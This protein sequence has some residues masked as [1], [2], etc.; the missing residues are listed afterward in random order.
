MAQF[1][2]ISFRTATI[3][4]LL[5]L[6]VGPAAA[7]TGG[8]EVR[9]YDASG[10]SP[11]AG[12]SVT[13]SSALGMVATTAVSTGADGVAFFPVLRPGGGYVVEVA[14][15]G[16]ARVRVTDVRVRIQEVSRIPIRLVS[17]I[18]ESVKVVER[19]AEVDL[20]KTSRS[21]TFDDA[22]LQ[23]LPSQ[24]RF[25][26]SRL[27]LAPGVVDPDGDGNPNVHGARAVDFQTQ[28]GGVSNQDPLTGG[29]MSYL[30]P[31]SIE[32]I[33][34][35]GAGAGVEFGRA[36]GGFAQ[37]IQKQGSNEFEGLANLLWRS[38]L[39][40]GGA[41]VGK[42]GARAPSY[43][44][45]QPAI[46]LS[47]PII[48]DRLWYRLSHEYISRKEPVTVLDGT[49]LATREQRI[50]S[51]QI[52]WQV[53]PRNKLALA[54]SNDPLTRTYVGASTLTTSDSTQ[55]YETG[56]PT[57][58]LNWT[59]PASPDVLVD[60]V[61]S[62]QNGHQRLLPMT[63]GTRNNC[64]VGLF[65][66]EALKESH[67]TDT[68]TGI[69]SGPYAS[70]QMDERQRLT[71][72]SQASIFG[73]RFLG[74]THQ[75]KA[76]INIENERYF[77][78]L[79][80][81]PEMTMSV[82]ES[83]F[84]DTSGHNHRAEYASI[85]IQVASP[86][87]ARVNATDVA[88]G[89]FVEDQVKPLPNLSLTLGF[90]VDRE[91]LR[92]TGYEP[93]DP[94]AESAEF[95]RRLEGGTS[96]GGFTAAAASFTS[97]GTLKDLVA[98]MSDATGYSEDKLS[99]YISVGQS[100]SQLWAKHRRPDDLE[101]LNTNPSPRLS[102]AWDPGGKGKSKL[103]LT[104]GR[105]YGTLLLAVPLV[106]EEPVT[107][108]MGLRAIRVPP[109]PLWRRVSVSSG[110]DPTVS[111]RV[112]DR[113]LRTPYQDEL[114]ISLEHE[115]ARETLARV[116]FISRR[117]QDQLQDVDINHHK[118]DYGRCVQQ[119]SP[120]RPWIVGPPDGIL[121]DCDGTLVVNQAQF[122]SLPLPAFHQPDGYLDSYTYNPG[123]G[124]IYRVGNEDT[125]RYK[126]IV[127]EVVRRQYRNWQMQAS[128]TW[129]RAL[130]NGEDFSSNVGD[131]PANRETEYG[132]LAYDQRNVVKVNATT[133]T[134][135]GFRFGGT[136]SW[137]SGLPY[138]IVQVASV[139]DSRP[140]DYPS[141]FVSGI[142]SRTRYSTHRRNDQRNRPSLTLNA[143][144][145]KEYNL[146]G[147]Q[148]LQISLEV[149][150]LLNDRNYV[151]YNPQLGYG[152]QTNG[153]N[154]ATITPGREYQVGLRLAF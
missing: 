29:W 140:L 46:Q 148:N 123:W 112:V 95:L 74:M 126:G 65:V 50:S 77:R 70:T 125:A 114:T 33:E 59:A 63:T 52:T 153:Q 136:A 35:I 66:P 32:E 25:Y 30:N 14:F 18:R 62:Y 118:G 147:G 64:T 146:S 26:Q 131:D 12:A 98:G 120:D 117:F 110:I 97:F 139:A 16:F 42:A 20:D 142:R 61:L 49:A 55:R 58:A 109:D 81:R 24:G 137:M 130:G 152:R 96:D 3:A 84:T 145:D 91:E 151:I 135:W 28:V 73:G 144:L 69:S 105:Y 83:V 154:D 36:Q 75:I 39:M 44:W 31:D 92:G 89:F 38:S 1:G 107:T 108:T 122:G 60:T 34:V 47:G 104:A 129:S 103:A 76:G 2:G 43:D 5:A 138:S 99:Q 124:A 71:L 143:K 121:D 119:T 53:S 115:I 54:I 80:K 86:P 128:Y 9:V 106:E 8:I 27:T 72:K 113:G 22:F 37:V 7:E 134:P 111:A 78:Y 41:L 6:A 23:D 40:D 101:I 116:S 94:A 10:R 17:E 90:R 15:P 19:R 11:V 87:T 102:V 133:I 21:T 45:I 79:E 51:D 132:Y 68:G 150:N 100:S 88:Y 13:L 85:S 82:K 56:G 4:A 127:L 93:F 48:K 57:F 149:F 141:I 67:C